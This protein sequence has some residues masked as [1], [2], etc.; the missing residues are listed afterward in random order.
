[1]GAKEARAGREWR[2]GEPGVGTA[3]VREGMP[4]TP[5][6]AAGVCP[7]QQVPGAMATAGNFP[8]RR[9]EATPA[10]LRA[11]KPELLSAS[12]GAKMDAKR[13]PGWACLAQEPRA[14]H[15]FPG[16]VSCALARKRSG[17]SRGG[18]E[19]G[20]ALL[21]P[22][23]SVAPSGAARRGAAQRSRSLP[24]RRRSAD[25]AK[26]RALARP[27]RPRLP[28]PGGCSGHRR[29]L[30]SSARP[31]GSNRAG[32]APRSRRLPLAWRSLA[33]LEGCSCP[34]PPWGSSSRRCSCL[35][36]HRERG[37]AAPHP[38][39][40][41]S[42]SEIWAG[43]M[44]GGEGWLRVPGSRRQELTCKQAVFLGSGLLDHDVDI[45][46]NSLLP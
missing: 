43:G 42:R 10:R 46:L 29:W 17:C 40:H 4:S 33:G 18:R 9:P 7:P 35:Q 41:A 38:Q 34:P 36:M 28:E 15:P 22:G 20:P 3:T 19:P 37:L 27:A 16:V 32:P 8:A 6:G 39:L 2:A 1:M 44:A 5:R 11:A 21:S 25:G 13:P 30:E 14:S 24:G 31:L 26:P 12:G 23:A 45:L